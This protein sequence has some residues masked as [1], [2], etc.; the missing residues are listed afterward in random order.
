[1][2]HLSIQVRRRMALELILLAAV[3][4]VYLA[5][6]PERHMGV[7]VGLALT[8]LGLVGL[9]AK[10]TRERVWGPPPSAEFDR[11]RRCTIN[12]SLFTIP[13]LILFAFYG[14]I[15][16][17]LTADQHPWSAVASRLIPLNFFFTLLLYIPWALLQQTLFQFYLLG[18]LRAILPFASPLLVSILNGILYGAVHWPNQAVTIVTIL[19]GVAWSY[20]YHRDR[21]TI[22][23]ALSHAFLGTTFYFWVLNRDILE[24]NLQIWAH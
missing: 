23:I 9:S 22:P 21:F 2:P 18:R 20:S 3:T 24:L 1:M 4:G 14:G 13:P 10:Y 5:L 19:G 16:A 8:A 7:D 12:M 6:M 17:Y 15:H 11:V